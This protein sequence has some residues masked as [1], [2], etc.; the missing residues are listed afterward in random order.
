MFAR[1]PPK[2]S[3]ACFGRMIIIP[4]CYKIFCATWNDPSKTLRIGKQSTVQSFKALR[5]II[6]AGVKQSLRLNL[7]MVVTSRKTTPENVIE[8]YRPRQRFAETI[9]LFVIFILS[10]ELLWFPSTFWRRSKQHRWWIWRRAH[11]HS[12]QC[13]CST[14]TDYAYE[15]PAELLRRRQS[16]EQIEEA[17]MDPSEIRQC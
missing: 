11:G 15:I 2:F 4:C 10:V 14:N 6:K 16:Y 7:S 1:W 5:K 17:M 8:M 9:H 12:R 3:N 13:E